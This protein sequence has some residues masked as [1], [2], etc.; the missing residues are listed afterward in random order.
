MAEVKSRSTMPS[1]PAGMKHFTIVHTEWSKGWGGQEI[2]IFNEAAGVTARGHRV[3]IVARPECQILTRAQAVGLPTHAL[4]MRNGFDVRAIA[5]LARIIRHE[6]VD[7]VNTHSSV[8]S[9]VGALA[10][11]LTR[12]K[13]IRTRHLSAPFRNCSS[14]ISELPPRLGLPKMPRTRKANPPG[15]V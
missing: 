1:S 10:A 7:I 8:D 3:L 15:T 11:K 4:P 9:W 14:R 2:R 12:A 6:R 5:G 13:L